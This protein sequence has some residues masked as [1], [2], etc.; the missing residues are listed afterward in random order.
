[1]S[2]SICL[3][4]NT[5]EFNRVQ[6]KTDEDSEEEVTEK[7]EMSSDDDSDSEDS[8]YINGSYLIVC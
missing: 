4:I 8:I 3:V 1:M 2:L 5:D 6:I 7:S